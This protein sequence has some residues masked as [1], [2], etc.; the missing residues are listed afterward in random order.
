MRDVASESYASQMKELHSTSESFGVGSVTAKHYKVIADLIRKIGV[1]SVLDY[2]CGK[3]NLLEYFGE[4]MPELKVDGFDIASEKY[5]TLSD[6]TYDM[7]VCLDVME[8]VEFGAISNVLMEIRTRTRKIFV[9]SIANYTAG[10]VLSDGRN[11]H[12]TQL[13]FST[14]FALLSGFFRVDQFLRT[15]KAEGLFICSS[16]K[17]S[18]DWR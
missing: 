4:K 2:G 1:A 16:M 8:H 3:G 6:E 15:G 7:V 14:W 18:A 10:K 5:A 13:P 17:I 9:C 12:L 11:A